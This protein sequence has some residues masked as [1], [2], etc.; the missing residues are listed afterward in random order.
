MLNFMSFISLVIQFDYVSNLHK[1]LLTMSKTLQ[2][3]LFLKTKR[4]LVVVELF[5]IAVNGFDAK[6]SAK[7]SVRCSK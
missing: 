4:V 3:K 2:K 1:F 7:I 5:T 6:K